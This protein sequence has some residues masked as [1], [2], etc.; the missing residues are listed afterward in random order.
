MISG[1]PARAGAALACLPRYIGRT[2]RLDAFQITMAC[3]QK[4][5]VTRKKH[6]L[7]RAMKIS[8]TMQ[9]NFYRDGKKFLSRCNGISI[10]IEISLH[11]DRNLQPSV[12]TKKYGLCV[13]KTME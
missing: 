13:L 10:A 2:H 11:R 12:G 5:A 4:I 8:I 7:C 6:C 1:V 3:N 9:Q